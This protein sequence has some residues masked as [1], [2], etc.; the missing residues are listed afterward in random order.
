VGTQRIKEEKLCVLCKPGEIIS[1]YPESKGNNTPRTIRHLE[2]SLTYFHATWCIPKSCQRGV[3]KCKGDIECS[4]Y[5]SFFYSKKIMFLGPR[6]VLRDPL[7]RL[8]QVCGPQDRFIRRASSGGKDRMFQ[9]HFINIFS[10]LLTGTQQQK[11]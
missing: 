9:K 6:P 2:C 5:S 8:L 1:G 3:L 4:S 11:K 10:T 7:H